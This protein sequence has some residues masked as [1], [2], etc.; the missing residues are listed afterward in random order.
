[1]LSH[2]LYRHAWSLPRHPLRSR[3]AVAGGSAAAVQ[4]DH[5]EL[6]VK[7]PFVLEAQ[8]QPAV[9]AA[10]AGCAA[11]A[12]EA[13]LELVRRRSPAT[14]RRPGCRQ[15]APG[16]A[17]EALLVRPSPPL[18]ASRI[19]AVSDPSPAH[20]SK[21]AV[22]P[23]A[24]ARQHGGASAGARRGP[25]VA[26]SAAFA[27]AARAPATAAAAA[28]AAAASS[29]AAVTRLPGKASAATAAAAG[30]AAPAAPAAGRRVGP[31]SGMHPV[32]PVG[33][34][35][36]ARAAAAGAAAAAA[37]TDAGNRC[38]PPAPP[39]TRDKASEGRTD[40]W[41]EEGWS[42]IASPTALDGGPPP[43]VH[44]A[45][46]R[47]PAGRPAAARRGPRSAPRRAVSPPHAQAPLC[48]GGGV[49]LW[50]CSVESPAHSA[51]S[52]P[53]PAH[54]SKAAVDPGSAA[55]P[56]GG[57]SAGAR[58]GPTVARSAAFATA[59]R[60]PATAAAAASAAAAS[61]H[62]A[63]T[64]L[65]GKAS[66]ATAAAAGAAAPAAPA[67]GRRVGPV[68]GR[69]PVGCLKLARAAAAAVAAA[70][71]PTDAGNRCPPPAPPRVRGRG[72]RLGG[73]RLPR[74]CHRR[75][76]PLPCWSG[77]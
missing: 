66:A 72:R 59:A 26:R 31:V 76:R 34:L 65:P 69:H 58:R 8:R 73:R 9:T 47:V 22:D 50:A 56:H 29:H 63:V 18:F 24:A 54:E 43:G 52:D 23:G 57:A 40:R 75:L 42:A 27:T 36:L 28:S 39:R 14:A 46:A 67:A 12:E 33:C 49:A 68:A 25:T 60:A 38:P 1:M 19:S 6:V 15:A 37:P 71:A 5:N 7:A 51:V 44:D 45:R 74:M 64:R 62:A 21:A 20:E 3:L 55:R 10:A 35:K 53:S 2:A 48:P 70:A 16:A 17:E 32:P 41:V 11:A 4:H 13:L 61:S 77:R 30:A